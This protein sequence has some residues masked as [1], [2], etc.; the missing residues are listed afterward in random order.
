MR[1][2][3]LVAAI[4]LGAGCQGPDPLLAPA[5]KRLAAAAP[6]SF[7]VL[8]RSSRGPFVIRARRHWSPLG[9]DRFHYLVSHRYFDE[10]RFFR[11]VG[12]FVAQWGLSGD[13][14]VNRAWEGKSIPDEPVQA[15]N[16]RGRIAFA[17]GGP[18]T[19]TV[20]LYLNYGDNGRLDTLNTFGFP[21]I[22]E[23]IEGM[24]AVDSLNFEYGGTRTDR[25]PGPSQDSI[26]VAGNAY[27]AR[28][29]PRLD[30][31]ST[32]RVTRA[33]RR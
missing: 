28:L 15:S 5:P 18:N 29:Y 17:R 11:V 21:P 7:D 25:K 12:G 8:V 3:L 30:Y 23:V 1:R 31:I 13:P 2:L 9:V 33:W 19:R 6:D 14:A 24:A 16:T 26:R 10:N 27:L 4:G 22:G 32:A 20:Q